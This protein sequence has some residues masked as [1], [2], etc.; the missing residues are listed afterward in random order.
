MVYIVDEGSEFDAP[1]DK[2]WKLA[3]S[4][5]YHKHS[6]QKN[7]SVKMEGEAAL[8]SFDTPTPDGRTI[9]QTIKITQVPPVG[10]ILEYVEGD[11]AGTKAFNYYTPKGK[12]TGV[13]VV[14]EWVSK[15]IPAD[16]LKKMVM[17]NLETAFNEDQQNLK[18]LK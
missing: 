5:A 3:Q 14:G 7:Q 2:V 16:Q 15:S 6:F 4:E 17:K 12:K 11:F 18:S 1:I 10:E 13:T 8:L 9:H